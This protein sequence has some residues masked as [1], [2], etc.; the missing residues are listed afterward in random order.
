MSRVKNN[1]CVQIDSIIAPLF[2]LFCFIERLITLK[3]FLYFYCMKTSMNDWK[4]K[5]TA[6]QYHVLREKGTERAFTGKFVNHHGDGM[7]TCAACGAE[8]FSSDTKFDSG[9]G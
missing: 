7:Y 1:G 8:L 6:E 9:T 5:L 3:T 2:F 4:K